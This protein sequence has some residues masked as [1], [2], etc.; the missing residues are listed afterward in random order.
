MDPFLLVSERIFI[1]M[2]ESKDLLVLCP[3]VEPKVSCRRYTRNLN[4]MMTRMSVVP[5][6]Q[7][8]NEERLC[9]K[10][11]FYGRKV[12][13]SLAV[14]AGS[15]R[16]ITTRYNAI[17][18]IKSPHSTRRS[19]N[20]YIDRL[21]FLTLRLAKSLSSSN[22]IAGII[23]DIDIYKIRQPPEY[24]RTTFTNVG[25][26][27]NS[28]KQKGLLQPVIVRTKQEGF[29]EMV[30]GNRR[31]QACKSLGWRKI[32]S[33]IVELDDKQAFEISLIENIHRRSLNPIEE[34][35]AF[36]SYV[37]DLGWGGISDL[38][39]K[40]GKSISYVDKRLKLL[41]LPPEIIENISNSTIST[42]VAEELSFIDDANKQLEIARI[43]TGKKI[44]SRQ[45]RTLVREFK[46][47]FDF[48]C[49]PSAVTIA[50][51]YERTLRSFDKSITALKIAMNKLCA[52]IEQTQD[53]WIVYGILMEHKAM[54]SAQID[55]LIKE[56]KKM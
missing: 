43:A 42:S 34:A 52:I 32:I 13:T 44:T 6:L 47:S 54:L 22:L 10:S 53:N 4:Q 20:S 37:K 23:E 33:H 9:I 11:I 27:A 12:S 1:H 16:W 14:S 21:G 30:A 55:L 35:Y 18:E 28:I 25:E 24:Y 40:I 51:R 19:R 26:L 46:D 49:D 5:W 38:A 56:K 36:R 8:P 17:L 2:S 50:D 39:S 48:E 3:I 15:A 45:A 29:F 7:A 41:D 31:L